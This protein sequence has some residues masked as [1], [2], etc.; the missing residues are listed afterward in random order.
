[1][2][3]ELSAKIITLII[4]LPALFAELTMG[5]WVVNYFSNTSET[6][7]G[8]EMIFMIPV[9][10]MALFVADLF[11]AIATICII[12]ASIVFIIIN[13]IKLKKEKIYQANSKKS[14]NKQ[15]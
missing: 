12:I 2:K 3:K 8:I 10:M 13:L 6:D 5:Y 14:H 11:A 15:T 9:F 7:F 4:A 1:M